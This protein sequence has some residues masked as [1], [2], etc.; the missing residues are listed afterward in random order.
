MEIHNNEDS[1]TTTVQYTN[2]PAWR[3]VMLGKR[4]REKVLFLKDDVLEFKSHCEVC[5]NT[6]VS[7]V[8]SEGSWERRKGGKDRLGRK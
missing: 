6:K 1:K 4:R 7:Q 5:M 8:F 3:E 2:A